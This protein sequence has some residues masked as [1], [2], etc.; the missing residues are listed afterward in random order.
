VTEVER[1]EGD[2]ITLQD[3]FLFDN[4]AG[5]DDEGRALGSLKATGLRPKFVEKMAYANVHVDPRIFA[6]QGL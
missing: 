5:F 6:R 3:V 1:M 4:S 2:I